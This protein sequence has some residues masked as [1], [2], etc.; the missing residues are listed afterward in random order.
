MSF[1]Y[2]P[3][4]NVD[5]PEIP[6]K[7]NVSLSAS[8]T[9]L[10]VVDMQNDFVK[11]KGSLLVPSAKETVLNIKRLISAARKKDVVVCYTQDTHFKGDKEW[12]IW[13]KHCEKG[14]WGWE[15]IKELKPTKNDLVFQKNRY[16]G[17]YGTTLNHYLSNVW[18]IENLILTGTVSNICVAQTAASAGL[19]WYNIVI[20]AD[21]ISALTEFDQALT[22]RQV[23]FLFNGV[24]VK[25]SNDIKFK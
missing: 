4:K 13:P 12:K 10:I 8:K 15:I 2:L 24:I 11:D 22:L 3:L 1:N 7:K 20:P 6:I 25:S 5:V 19:R 14:S 17:F 9:A 16:D 21:S 23:S 18:K